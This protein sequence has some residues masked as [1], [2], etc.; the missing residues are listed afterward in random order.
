MGA[1]LGQRREWGHDA[2]LDWHLLDSPPHRGIQRLVRDLNH[3]YRAHPP[4]YEVDYDWTGFQWIDCQDASSSVLTFLR[5][6]REPADF[7]VVALNFTPVVREDYRVGV[8]HPGFYQELLNSDSAIYGGSNVGNK[9]GVEA[10][11]I[12]WNGQPFSV[13]LRL[14]P[15]AALYLKL[16]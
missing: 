15:L 6:A 5:L 10:E 12:P 11:P 9:G 4:F 3:F 13:S 8:P 7:V 1:E 16:A 2:S 14:P